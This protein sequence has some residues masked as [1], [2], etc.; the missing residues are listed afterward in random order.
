MNWPRAFICIAAIASLTGCQDVPAKSD[1]VAVFLIDASGSCANLREDF[2]SAFRKSIRQLPGTRVRVNLIS[3][4]NVKVPSIDF[5]VPKQGGPLN[6]YAEQYEHEVEQIAS[7]AEAQVRSLLTQHDRLVSESTRRNGLAAVDAEGQSDILL[8]LTACASSFRQD[9]NRDLSRKYLY[10]YTDGCNQSSELNLLSRSFTETSIPITIKR[11]TRLNLVP[12]L[13][14]V[15]VKSIGG[16]GAGKSR[17]L[18]AS[19][20]QLIVS[21]WQQYFEATGASVNPANI[22]QD[23]SN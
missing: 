19:Q 13:D 18:A 5:V 7:S 2:L 16:L 6:E 20:I 8:C 1:G 3:T 9:S 14:G 12:K 11:L 4:N 15:T 17:Q 23:V 22:G 21:F 10:L